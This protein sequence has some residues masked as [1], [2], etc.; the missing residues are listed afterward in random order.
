MRRGTPATR[1]PLAPL[2]P[3]APAARLPPRSSGHAAANHAAMDS[4]R[5]T[6]WLLG[7][8][9]ALALAGLAAVVAVAVMVL[10]AAGLA[11]A[12]RLA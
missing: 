3:L 10:V 2:T 7:A 11:E 5:W 1:H 8:V 4:P 9:W 12:L 6:R